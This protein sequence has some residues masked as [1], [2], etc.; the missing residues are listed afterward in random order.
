M[1]QGICRYLPGEMDCLFTPQVWYP[2]YVHHP[3]LRRLGVSPNIHT[4]PQLAQAPFMYKKMTLPLD[5]AS[6]EETPRAP[7]RS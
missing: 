7:K 4:L 6:N 3:L 5:K 2:G 1:I